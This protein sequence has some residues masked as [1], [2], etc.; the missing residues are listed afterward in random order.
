MLLAAL[1]VAAAIIASPFLWRYAMSITPEVAPIIAD[2][3]GLTAKV[4]VL[5]A[6]EVAAGVA[7]VQ[8][9]L[10]AA[11]ATIASRDA[12]IAKMTADHADDVAG[13]AGSVGDLKVAMTPPT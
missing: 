5:I 4:S 9:S 10:D 13:L 3:D 12:T 2:I 6:G 11:T 8:A 7:P 1:V